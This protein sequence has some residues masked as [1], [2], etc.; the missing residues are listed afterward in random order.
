MFVKGQIIGFIIDGKEITGK[1][2]AE[3]EF[4][5]EKFIEIQQ[6]SS[7]KL[8]TYVPVYKLSCFSCD[9]IE[10]TQEEKDLQ[11]LKDVGVFDD[12][13]NL[14]KEYKKEVAWED[15]PHQNND[16]DVLDSEFKEI[17][18][19]SK[20]FSIPKEAKIVE[21]PEPPKDVNKTNMADLI[22]ERNKSI[23]DNL[24]KK[25]KSPNTKPVEVQYGLPS[26][27]QHTDK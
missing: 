3:R 24:A 27:Q 25:L 15:L 21:E 16:P 8:S 6:I 2:V 22:A 19:K 26:F 12:N 9:S 10:E 23:R 4:W 20:T 13:G 17:L 18:Y 7:P 5:S 11:K 14:N 1:F